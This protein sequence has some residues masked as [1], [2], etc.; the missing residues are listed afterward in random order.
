MC[1]LV[2]F[3]FLQMQRNDTLSLL[4]L[5]MLLPS[6]LNE[7]CKQQKYW[8]KVIKDIST[9]KDNFAG[10]C[11]FLL[12]WRR[13]LY[14]FLAQSEK[15]KPLCCLH[16]TCKFRSLLR[17]IMDFAKGLPLELHL[18]TSGLPY[19]TCAQMLFLG[20]PRCYCWSVRIKGDHPQY[21][22]VPR[23]PLMLMLAKVGNKLVTFLWF[24]L[25]N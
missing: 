3:T 15:A 9:L 16:L 7:G 1:L 2:A 22:W 17:F 10:H 5:P 21:S 25:R 19:P 20:L 14:P 13:F 4:S 18:V 6:A 8:C 12:S 11:F 24:E 23:P